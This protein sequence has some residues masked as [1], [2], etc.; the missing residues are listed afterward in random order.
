M[1]DGP[2]PGSGAGAGSE[3]FDRAA[4]HRPLEPYVHPLSIAAQSGHLGARTR[5]TAD[6][7]R[8]REL[9]NLWLDH[10]VGI[11]GND[12]KATTHDQAQNHEP[13]RGPSSWDRFGNERVDGAGGSGRLQRVVS[14]QSLS[15][16]EW[17]LNYSGRVAAD[18][19]AAEIRFRSTKPLFPGRRRAANAVPCSLV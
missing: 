9:T 19:R 11:R 16:F 13:N 3:R 6:L 5:G 8:L 18:E 12:G 10:R 2:A 1:C 17:R 15:G 4:I 7:R 14:F